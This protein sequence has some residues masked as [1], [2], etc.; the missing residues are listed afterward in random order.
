MTRLPNSDTPAADQSAGDEA[1]GEASAEPKKLLRDTDEKAIALARDLLANS[2]CI[3]LAVLEPETGF[4]FVSRVLHALDEDGTPVILV[5]ALSGHT[6]GLKADRRCSLLAGD[7]GKGD[8][9]AHP[10]IT[11]QCLAEAVTRES[12]LHVRLRERFLIRHPKSRLYIDFPDF[13]FIRLNVQ[14]AALNGGF[15]QAYRIQGR[16]LTR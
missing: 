11:V 2:S 12:E 8:P 9:L 14:N 6:R 3:A 16:E 10:R 7:P 1:T 15:G 4:P 5:S 13:S